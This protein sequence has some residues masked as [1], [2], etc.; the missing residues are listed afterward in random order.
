MAKKRTGRGRKQDRAR[1]GL[2]HD[3]LSFKKSASSGDMR[4]CLKAL[5]ANI[6]PH[7]PNVNVDTEF[8]SISIPLYRA[9]PI[10]LI[11]QL[12]QVCIR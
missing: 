8:V 9:V 1:I 2:A 6:D 12:G 11:F 4:D 7:H 5:C 3:Q 10:G